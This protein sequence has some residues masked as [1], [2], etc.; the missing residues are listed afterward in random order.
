[1]SKEQLQRLKTR[2][3]QI[4]IFFI[5]IFSL[6]FCY[7]RLEGDIEK[8]RLPAVPDRPVLTAGSRELTVSWKAVE[9]A[10]VYEVWF[11]TTDDSGSAQKQ[12][13]DISGG[14]T[15]TVIT[16]L[17]NETEYYVWIRA[18]NN[19]GTSGFSPAVTGTPS[20]FA[21]PPSAPSPTVTAGN[22][23]ITVN[24]QA[25]EGAIVYE[26]WTGTVND[27]DSAAKQGDDVSGL[28]AV[29]GGLTNGTTYY[30]WVKAKNSVGTSGF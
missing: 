7:C 2:R 12:G 24:W 10:D 26:V 13:D 1:M 16:G 17:L 6:F 22:G 30:V 29:I 27:P 8:R 5:F 21:V 11:G 9:R 25:A 18:K 20:A 15:N 23:Q 19:A 14:V 4:T 3:P 28:S